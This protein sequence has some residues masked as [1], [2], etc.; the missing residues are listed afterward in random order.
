MIVGIG[1]DII[2]ISRI[3]KALTKDAFRLRVFTAGE[4][5]YCEARGKGNAA[6]YAARFAG[7]EAV[8]KAL[9]TG[10]NGGTWQDIEILPNSAGQPQ[11]AL[12]GYFKDVAERKQIQEILI[13]LT[14]AREYAAAQ[15][16]AIGRDGYEGCNCSR[17]A[18]S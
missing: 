15:A 11:V 4:Q 18:N 16:I 8:L 7:K 3:K 13:S 6:S 10:F 14:H 9:G 5:A 1:M 2:E 12:F 17:N